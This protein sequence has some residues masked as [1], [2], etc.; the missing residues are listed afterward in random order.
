M[1]PSLRPLPRST[2]SKSKLAQQAREQAANEEG[3]RKRTATTLLYC[4]LQQYIH[5]KGSEKRNK[6]TDL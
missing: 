1:I 5:A 4:M 6:K 2:A 3:N